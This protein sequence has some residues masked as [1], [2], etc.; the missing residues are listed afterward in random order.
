MKVITNLI[1]GLRVA[2]L[3][4][5]LVACHGCSNIP[6]EC[7]TYNKTTTILNTEV[8]G[9]VP[10]FTE[11]QQEPEQ[12]KLFTPAIADL[13]NE[14]HYTSGHALPR[15]LPVTQVSRSCRGGRWY[16]ISEHQEGYGEEAQRGIYI[17]QPLTL[18]NLYRLLHEVGH[19]DQENIDE[20]TAE[21]NIM[22]QSMAGY[23]LMTEQENFDRQLMGWSWI[24]QGNLLG[25]ELLQMTEDQDYDSYSEADV[26]LFDQLTKFKGDFTAVRRS[27]HELK[28]SGRLDDT[29]DEAIREFENTYGETPGRGILRRKA[30]MLLNASRNNYLELQR[31]FSQES[32]DAYFVASSHFNGSDTVISEIFPERLP[33]PMS[34]VMS[35]GLEGYDCKTFVDG[36]GDEEACEPGKRQ[37]DELNA[38]SVRLYQ[39][40][41]CCDAVNLNSVGEAQFR[42]WSVAADGYLYKGSKDKPLQLHKLGL[43][44]PWGVEYLSI[45]RKRELES[46]ETC[47][48]L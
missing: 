32:A 18:I 11:L 45:H 5:G 3:G 23:F 8:D 14:I 40:R 37:C 9:K 15:D 31:R 36:F 16:S 1:N 44:W 33:P 6:E 10:N 35:F 24:A 20:I 38:A 2:V 27:L 47:A 19:F 12:G 17:T 28:S 43:E 25:S 22:E 7:R 29:I 21:L 34:W 41:L 39:K 48:D 26:F 13:I 4:L 42:R 30:D 46:G